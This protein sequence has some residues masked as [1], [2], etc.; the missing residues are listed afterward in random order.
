[1]SDG[2]KNRLRTN[3]NDKCGYLT[4]KKRGRKKYNFTFNTK[5]I[6]RR[7]VKYHDNFKP[8][9]DLLFLG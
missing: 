9:I 2:I 4:I 1:M 3:N 6:K 7:V 5:N 8:N